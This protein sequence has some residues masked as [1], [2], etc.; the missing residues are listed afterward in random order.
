MS[1][2]IYWFTND[3][4]LSDNPA[5][6]QAIKDERSLGYV[7]CI[8]P[9]WFFPNRFNCI[10]MGKHR[11]SFLLESLIDLDSQLSAYGQYLNI[12]CEPPG[13]LFQ[14]LYNQNGV[15]RVYHADNSDFD[16]A[17]FFQSL[18]NYADDIEVIT[19]QPNYL[20]QETQ[21]PFTV[22][23]LPQSFSKFRRLIEKQATPVDAPISTPTQFPSSFL[24][25]RNWRRTV[26][27]PDIGSGPSFEGGERCAQEHLRNYFTS[28]RPQTYKET[29]N[30]LDEW[31]HS[32]K[33]SPSLAMGC[34]SPRQ[35]V[36]ALKKHEHQFSANQST[37]WIL[38]ELLWREYF[39]LYARRWGSRLF[40]FSGINN[41]K[42]LTSFYGERFQ[43]WCQGTTPYPIVN[44]CMKQLN[45]TGYMSNRGRQLVASC[46]VH[47]LGLDWRYGAAYFEQQLIDYDVASNWGNW[48][49]LAG[50]GADPR[51]CRQFNLQKQTETYDPDGEFISA[52]GGQ[53]YHTQIDSVDA[54]DWPVMP[55]EH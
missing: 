17:T 28:D 40:A 19:G 22:T 32:T 35:V 53:T 7:F 4:R 23:E 54:A 33:L 10:A 51:G 1:N 6:I 34:I 15:R 20:F 39:S 48:Q 16:Q 36:S 13:K 2:A 47:E 26:R 14:R 24:P 46:F 50:V 42:P 29:R 52:W 55:Q 21:L 8:D 37:Y 41:Q 49:Y 11:Y 5:L 27:Q 30:S 12:Y 43:Q 38:F 25:H 18:S 31:T 9:T 45:A 44:A 3:L